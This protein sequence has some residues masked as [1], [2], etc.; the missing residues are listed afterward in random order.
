MGQHKRAVRKV[1]LAAAAALVALAVAT[2]CGRVAAKVSDYGPKEPGSP[3]RVEAGK[4]VPLTV[5]FTNTGNRSGT[6]LVRAVVRDSLGARAGTP[7]QPQTVAVD[8]GKS[9][10]ATWTY[11]VPAA[12]TYTVQFIV[13]KDENTAYDQQ[14]K[15]PAQ[16]IVGLPAVASTKFQVGDR[17]RVTSS[18]NV[19]TGPG[20]EAARVSHVNYRDVAPA[21]TEGKVVGGPERADD[22]VWWRVEFDVGYTGWCIE[23]ALG[24]AASK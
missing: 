16:V 14:P 5:T 3:V 15:T 18:V 11:T 10:T 1:L 13:G 12:G 19:R 17:V 20:K 22:Y 8:P 4:S 21:G 24:K 9:H 7:P 2:G 6:F 23:D